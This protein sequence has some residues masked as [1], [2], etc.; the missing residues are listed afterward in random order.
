MSSIPILDLV[1]GMVF[2]YFLLSL[3]SSS[4]V[5]MILTGLN[6]R[7]KMLGK[8]LTDTFKQPVPQPGRGTV[9]L[10]KA[11]MNHFAITALSA[12]DKSTSYIAPANFATALL[13]RISFDPANIT[14]IPKTIDDYITALQNTK[15]LP[16]ELQRVFL[17]FAIEA[18]NTFAALSV[19][20][21]G[22]IDLFKAKIGTWFDSN[23]DRVGGSMKKRYSRPFTFLVAAV[24]ALSL[25]ADSINMAKYLYNNP[26]A[27][28]KIAAS[29]YEAVHNDEFKKQVDNFQATHQELKA[30]TGITLEQIQDTIAV[31]W[32][33]MNIAKAALEENSVPLGWSADEYNES[34]SKVVFVLRKFAG[35]LFTFFAVIMGAPF[36]FQILNKIANLRGTGE[37]PGAAN[38]KS[39]K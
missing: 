19:K 7:A 5:E 23:M 9:P 8:W 18:R 25:N 35:L 14:N 15:A 17:G 30:D 16:E 32:K 6:C 38:K 26:E 21:V 13:E 4:A 11:I 36:W 31:R 20:T 1:A 34:P 22:E 29:A 2:F 24:V 27:R 12:E 28:A 39:K 3:I 37:K 10:A 33:Q